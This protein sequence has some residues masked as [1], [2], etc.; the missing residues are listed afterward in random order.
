VTSPEHSCA[1]ARW[2]TPSP[3][4]LRVILVVLLVAGSGTVPV[5]ASDRLA[6]REV[7]GFLPY[8]QTGQAE[9][10]DLGT[11]TTLAWFGV[12]AGR[13]GHLVREVDGETPPGWTGW[14]GEDFTALR[15]RAQAEGVRVVLVVERFSWTAAARRST[16]RLLRDADARAT[17]ADEIAE[18][19][20]S[21]GADGVNLDF[22]PLPKSVSGEFV[23]LVRT[24]RRKL[25]A[26]DPSLQSTFDLTPDVESFPLHRLVADGA[27]DAA[28]L[29][30]YE[31]RAAGS[32]VAGSIA[33]LRDPGRHVPDGLDLRA[34]VTLAL[35]H[36]PAE[37][38]ILALPWYGR[39]WSTRS[40]AP[41]SKTRASD[42]YLGP[43]TATYAVSVPRA[44]SAGRNYDPVQASAWSAYRARACATCPLSWRQLWYDDV[45]S[46]R[47]KIGFAGRKGLRGVGVWALGYEGDRPDLWSAMRFSLD[48]PAD[49]APPKGSVDLEPSSVAGTTDGVPVVGSEVTLLLAAADDPDGSGVAFVRV[50]TRGKLAGDGAL[51]HGTTF[52]AVDSVAVT[53]PGATPVD[54]VFVPGAGADGGAADAGAGSPNPLPSRSPLPSPSATQDALATDSLEPLTIRVQWR[55]IAGNWSEP[56]ALRVLLDRAA[57]T[58]KD[59]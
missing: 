16:K 55:D 26:V 56:V 36:A 22:E 42:R 33:P 15:M 3:L 46:V 43:S 58:P 11:L 57:T 29:M 52:P 34:S 44:V 32:T 23:R 27:A 53:L 10:I 24:V 5:A 48:G 13:D 8:W 2:P 49:H 9:S 6:E 37:R 18:A 12:E 21:A 54:E 30:G 47:A 50:A 41:G 4:I 7:F 17:L 51:K 39:A 31:Y 40:D 59:G 14:T 28:I 20:A 35:A 19:V 38:I 25:D 45:D 1:R